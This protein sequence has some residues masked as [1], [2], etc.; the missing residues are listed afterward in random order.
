MGLGP[1]MVGVGGTRLSAEE[2]EVLQHPL[3]GGV[4]LF[5]RNY[6][7]PRQV[8]ALCAEIHSLRD[9]ALLVAVDQEGGRVQRFR[10]GFSRLPAMAALG[11]VHDRDPERALELAQ[12]MGWLMAAELRAVGVDLSFAPVLDL[13]HG[14]S[15]VIGDRS[16]HAD[17]QIVVRLADAYI[18]G[19]EQ[20]GLRAIGKHFPG[21]GGVVADSHHD[22]P[23]DTRSLMVLHEQDLVP[24]EELT[25]RRR[26]AGVMMAH[27]A[28]PDLD[29]QPASFSRRW[30]DGLLRREL[31]FTGVVFCDDLCME[32]A[33]SLG[34]L[35]ERARA[36]LDAG[37]DMVMVCN[38][39]EEI[40]SVLESLE[41]Y[42][43][44]SSQGLEE[45][46]GPAGPAL[47]DLQQD[48][49]WKLARDA[50][51]GLLTMMEDDRA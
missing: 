16:L 31:G 50:A 9:P 49:R 5:N 25:R 33:A 3:I 32:G 35:P 19:M 13:D 18:D 34:A 15:T 44:E 14:E 37:N 2:Q 46:R 11:R 48:Q 43:M 17:P 41:D 7:S 8:Q 36:A 39:L 45:L 47:S 24:F 38:D 51:Q 26:L 10:N 28:F 30:I 42:R 12:T 23:V 1:V 27:V 6:E 29:N 22:L 21:H 20:G 4:I 40:P